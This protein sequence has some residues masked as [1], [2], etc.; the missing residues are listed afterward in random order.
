M[1]VFLDLHDFPPE[2]RS[3]QTV[4]EGMGTFLAC[5]PPAHYPGMH[6]H[7]I[8]SINKTFHLSHHLIW[9]VYLFHQMCYILHPFASTKLCPTAG[10]SMSSP[11]SSSQR[12]ADG[13]F[14]RWRVTY[15][16]LML[17]PMTRPTISASPPS[18]WTSAPRASSAKLS[19]SLF[20]LMVSSN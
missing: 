10:S 1:C 14:L 17:E 6:I 8:I 7:F 9:S 15:T 12:R 11:T 2:S 4:H 19:S 20:T 3:P 13:L 16:L 18:I 5:Q